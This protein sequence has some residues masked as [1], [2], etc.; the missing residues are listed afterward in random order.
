MT[1]LFKSLATSA[2]IA[3][4]AAGPLTDAAYA[5]TASVTPVPLPTTGAVPA[6]GTKEQE[7][8][9]ADVIQQLLYVVELSRYI[10]GGISQIFGSVQSMT[11]LLGA[12]RD[13]AN[14]QLTA[15]TGTKTVPLANG[16]DEVSARDG[17]PGVREMAIEGLGGS[18]ANPPDISTVFSNLVTTYELDKVF[19]YKDEDRLNEV[20][21]AHMA[22]YGAVAAAIGD[23][24]Y[25]RANTSMGR[26]NGYITAL[27][28][29]PD[30]KTS[31]DINTRVNL[32]LAQQL[33]ELVRTQ[34][35]LTTIAGMHYVATL[36]SRAD[37]AD[38]LDLQ[39]LLFPR[40]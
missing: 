8:H 34:A 26:I 15:L 40:N 13:T 31:I 1:T 38:N 28:A 22:S 29:S 37:I 16:P 36:S 10:G 12:I 35:A 9:D 17:G 23:R 27:G 33:N 11:S 19:A 21:M 4:A 30:L 2:L 25:K 39:R 20:T 7:T 3:L 6:P 14:A 5:Q 32:E 18:V 24:A